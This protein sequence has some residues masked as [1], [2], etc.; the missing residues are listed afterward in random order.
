MSTITQLHPPFDKLLSEIESTL[1]HCELE[2]QN[3]IPTQNKSWPDGWSGELVD[4][5]SSIRKCVHVIRMAKTA[6]LKGEING[7]YLRR[8]WE[9]VNTK[10]E[11]AP[12]SD[13]SPSNW[14][15]WTTKADKARRKIIKSVGTKW[16]KE[17]RSGLTEAVQ[18]R[19]QLYEDNKLKKYIQ[20]I[21]GTYKP[22]TGQV[23]LIRDPTTGAPSLLTDPEQIKASE[24]EVMNTW[25][26]NNRR[27]WFMSPGARLPDHP[28]LADNPEKDGRAA[29][30]YKTTTLGKAR[31]N[32]PCQRH[33]T[34]CSKL[35]ELNTLNS[36]T[37][38]YGLMHME[39]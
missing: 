29:V 35:H 36:P 10:I 14:N 5:A 21:L 8:S 27:R 37:D 39:T 22:R 26:G 18:K 9:N 15:A 11:A 32:G 12:P 16:R 13:D 24:T 20:K 38:R 33:S 6:I 28:T 4:S 7:D 31:K 3:K 17:R 34:Q 25:M 19:D 23:L 2:H 30:H 1:V